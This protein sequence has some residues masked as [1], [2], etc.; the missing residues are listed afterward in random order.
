MKKKFISIML[1]VLICLMV[2]PFHMFVF[3]EDEYCPFSGGKGTENDPY[4]IK[5]AYD[6]FLFAELMNDIDETKKYHSSYY[7]QTADIDLRGENWIP[8]GTFRD[9]DD[10]GTGCYFIGVYNGNY[11]SISNL[12]CNYEGNYRGLFGRIG[13]NSTN[14]T[15]K[16]AIK[17]L[18]VYGKVKGTGYAIGGIAGEVCCGASIIN[19]SF[20]GDVTGNSAVGGIA[21]HIYNGG[22]IQSSY[23]NGNI[24]GNNNNIGGIVGNATVNDGTYTGHSDLKISDCYFVSKNT[25]SSSSNGRKGGIAGNIGDGGGESSC[26]ITVENNYFLDSACD[27]AVNGA[28]YQGCQKMDSYFMKNINELLGSPFVFNADENLND[29]YPV[30]EC[31]AT[32]YQ[33]KG[34]GTKDDP[35]Q[36]SSKEELETMRDLV[37]SKFF[38]EHYSDKCYIQ[39][40]DIDLENE[41]WT[42]IGTRMINNVDLSAPLFCGSYNGN[43]HTIRNLYINETENNKYFG[44]FGSH[45]GSGVI[46]NLIVYGEVNSNGGAVGGIAG[47]VVN[48]GGIIRN[49]AFIGDV[50][51]RYS[52]GGIAGVIFQNGLIDSCY[53]IGNISAIDGENTKDI[54]GIVGQLFAGDHYEGVS[55][56]QNCYNIGK[57]TGLKD[58]IGSIVGKMELRDKV[59]GEVHVINCYSIKNESST[60]ANGS[61][62]S[63]EVTALS[64]N[65][66]KNSATKLSNSFIKNSDSSVNNGY[67][68]FWWQTPKGDANDDG[69]FTILDVIILQK[70]LHGSGHLEKWQNADFNGDGIINVYD[71]CLMKRA[72]L[73][74]L[75]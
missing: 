40:A 17:N 16:C 2:V 24:S 59:Q 69:E 73:T 25:V 70:W 14:Y 45:R 36:I 39:T 19:C 29:G 42:P 9:A 27:G 23:C 44:L 10:N 58:S 67:P 15:N 1:S 61:Y 11:H 30:F 49:C 5:T 46:E 75:T 57:V 43:G 53:H 33:F 66:L 50:N 37:N 6:L 12:N 64:E 21:G 74:Y 41:D 8:I 18:S 54:G 38:T 7:I 55:T 56:V 34:S 68:I 52:V 3:A 47:E 62:N 4:Q 60:T 48:G 51:G 63:Y 72:L 28:N 65:M 26:T 35:Y 20:S 31:Q 13:E 22:Y 32:P 71:L